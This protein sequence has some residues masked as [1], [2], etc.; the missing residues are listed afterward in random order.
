[1]KKVLLVAT[2]QSH[3]A[4]FHKPT[5][6]MLKEHGYTVEVAAH[7]NLYL[8][9][10]LT[11]TEPDH[12]FEVPFQRSP[13]S[14]KNFKAYKVLKNI[15]NDGSYDIVHCNTPVGGI[16]TR[17][18][19]RKLRKQGLKVIYE[20]HGFHFFK[21]GSKLNWVLWY[22]LEKFFSRYTDALVLINKMDYELAK[23]DFRAKSTYRIPG[24]GVNLTQFNEKGRCN[25]KEELG[26]PNDASIVLSV[27]ELNK[28]KNHKA[29]I[30]ALSLM[31]DQ[32]VH[33]CIAGNGPLLDE[34]KAFALECGVE[35]RVHFLGY[36][37]DLPSIFKETNVFLLPSYREGLGM[38]AIEAMA[39]GLP[40]VSSNR[41]G[42]NDYS[43]EGVT[44]FKCHPDNYT[45]FAKSIDTIIENK[46]LSKKF[47]ENCKEI[48]KQ[49][50][51][52]ESLNQ[53]LQI[54]KEI[55]GDSEC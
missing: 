8:K 9:E 18:A 19:C 34:L 46:K 17:W 4:Q 48:A 27:G 52:Q 3:I 2:V 49:F 5:I 36:R 7:D 42:I 21:G 40:L 44:G 55:L 20:A 1:M 43:I 25:L 26:I 14:L 29:G 37:R 30:K 33:Y 35:H 53:I 11:L 45:F 38:A 6:N 32:T 51:L 12:V 24:V 10:A 54:Y 22:P 16:L 47:S 41:H 39:C 28:N 13:F 23:K 15:I 50:S 31:R